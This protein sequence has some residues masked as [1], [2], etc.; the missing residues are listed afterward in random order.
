MY[1]GEVVPG[2]PQH[3]HRGFETVTIVR[4]GLIDHSD[5]LGATA[6]FGPGDSQWLTAGN[7]IVHSEMFPLVNQQSNNPLELFQIWLNLPKRNKRVLPYFSML[8]QEKTPVV[9]ET[10]ALGRQTFIQ[11]IA[12]DL[13][14]VQAPPPPPDSWAALPESD[15]AIWAVRLEPD[16]LWTM[17]AARI[18]TGR[19]LFYFKGSQLQLAGSPLPSSTS[20]HLR[21]EVEVTLQNGKVDSELLLLQGKPIGEP[22]VQ[23]GP[24]VMNTREEIVEAI[25]D[26]R[27][28]TFGG[29]PWKS[30]GPVHPREDVRF[31]RYPDGRY[32]AAP[33]AESGGMAKRIGR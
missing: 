25:D 5:S 26:Y 28:T 10:D 30:D 19:Q 9:S 33:L 1:H 15:L 4:S 20:V 12:G 13:R 24:F 6:R 8:W 27:R 7:G 14:A 32:E 31:A 29:W 11:L 3:P 23:H 2:F 17:P 16:A 18:G 22:V 21:P